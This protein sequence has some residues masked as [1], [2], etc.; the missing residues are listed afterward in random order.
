M[1]HQFSQIMFTDGVKAAQ[2]HIGSRAQYDRFTAATGPNEK[3]ITF[4]HSDKNIAVI[5]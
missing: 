5:I 4:P 3:T 2:E 1:T